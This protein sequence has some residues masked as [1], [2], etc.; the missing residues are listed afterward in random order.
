MGMDTSMKHPWRHMNTQ[1]LR[2]SVPLY[3]TIKPYLFSCL[4]WKGESDQT[5]SSL[6]QVCLTWY[7]DFKSS[8]MSW[9]NLGHR[10]INMASRPIRIGW[11]GSHVSWAMSYMLM[12]PQL[13][14]VWSVL[15]ALGFMSM[16][17][18]NHQLRLILLFGK[19]LHS[20]RIPRLKWM[21][22]KGAVVLRFGAL[23]DTWRI[24]L[25]YLL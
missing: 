21:C 18:L 12:V 20:L 2:T 3:M 24:L 13:G 11:T 1:T 22:F 14:M 5:P 19:L 6:Q 9:W 25:S 15:L 7:T 8:M 23:A 4:F 17:K 16:C 10:S